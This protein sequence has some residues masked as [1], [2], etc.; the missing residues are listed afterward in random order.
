MA[1]KTAYAMPDADVIKSVYLGPVDQANT[2]IDDDHPKA[3]SVNRGLFLKMF[4]TQF[5]PFLWTI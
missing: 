2:P 3:S 1:G 5:E 4:R